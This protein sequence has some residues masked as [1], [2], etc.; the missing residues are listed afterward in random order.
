[1]KTS[2]K[3]GLKL[4]VKRYGQVMKHF[5]EFRFGKD[6]VASALSSK[7]LNELKVEGGYL[8]GEVR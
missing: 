8:L 1:M 5:A 6:T 3:L 2:K 4:Y 7:I